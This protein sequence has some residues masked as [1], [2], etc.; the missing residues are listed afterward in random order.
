MADKMNLPS[1][2]VDRANVLFKR[3]Q[4]GKHLRGHSSDGIIAA[5]LNIACRQEGVPRG[6]KEICAVS[7]VSKVES[8]RCYNYV[9]KVLKIS[10][11]STTSGD[12]MARFGSNLELPYKVQRVATDIAEQAVKMDIV[13]GRSPISVAAA[14]IYMASQASEDKRSAKQIEEITGVAIGTIRQA[15]RLMYPQAAQLFPKDFE[16]A[17]T[18]DKLPRL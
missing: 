3:V 6:F 18:I 8:S 11:D 10:V 12:F 16:F 17:T 13:S 1:C 15:F 4:D 14:A 9:R 2:I 5:C 7:M